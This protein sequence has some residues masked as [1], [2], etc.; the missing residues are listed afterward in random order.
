MTDSV[1]SSQQA[2]LPRELLAPRYWPNWFAAGLLWCIAQ[3][4]YRI[5]IR[6]GEAI[7]ALLYP[8]VP[9]RRRIVLTNLKLCFPELSAKQ[10]RALARNN[11]RYTGR[12]LIETALS[13]WTPAA[14]LKPLAHFQGLEYVRAAQAEG[15]GVL[16]IG[17]HFTS[18]EMAARLMGLQT[19][20]HVMYRRND[21]P[22][23]EYLTARFRLQ[24][25]GGAI[26]RDDIRALVRRL[27][28]GHTVWYAP[29]QD[30]GRRHS[31]FVPFF[32][33]PAAT[34]AATSRIAKLSGAVLI[35]AMYHGRDDASGY[36]IT[37]LPPLAEF[38]GA[39]P[40]EDAARL[41]RFFEDAVKR[42][43]EQYYWVHR[44]F[45]TRPNPNDP[46]FY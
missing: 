43:P 13:W 5:A 4:P 45:K 26:P 25:Y 19:S 9:R 23:F 27:R 44:R 21:N 18:M 39:S 38:P 15:R 14:K 12:M 16:L 20:F 40:E 36:D 24:R 46:K 30:Y 28:E 1:A 34:I 41:N 37:F 33:V 35:P 3:L 10:R 42:A 31:V 29:D 7:G 17:G 22:V 2:R 11:F 32:G 8:L 6:I